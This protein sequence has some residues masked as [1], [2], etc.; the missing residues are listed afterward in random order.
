MQTLRPSY[1][2]EII[3]QDNIKKQL[4]ISIDAAKV[5]RDVL[6]HTLFFGGPGTGKTT[7][8]RAIANELDGKF[9]SINGANLRNIKSILPVLFDINDKTI[10]FIDEI[11]RM[12]K[13]VED[14]LLPCIEDF[15]LQLTT[16]NSVESYDIP[17]FTLVGAT[18]SPGSIS[19]PLLDRFKRKHFIEDYTEENMRAI[20]ASSCKKLDISI[21]DE[22]IKHII[23]VSRG[24]PRV[25]N[26]VLEW[27]RDYLTSK[28]I[29]RL[30]KEDL[31]DVL[32]LFGIDKNGLMTYDN[33]YIECL[34]R[35]GGGP[36]GLNTICNDLCLDNETVEYIIEPWL[37]KRRFI[38]KT[39]KGRILNYTNIK[40]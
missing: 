22:C 14:F 15:K 10:L 9:I 8:A 6:G 19:K 16:S 26:N 33:K 34:E 13:V 20:A 4:Q 38:L 29:A 11:H 5:R 31:N 35:M 17:R 18:T 37:V 28:Y 36:V 40:V 7:L 39:P 30:K 32:E 25:L 2:N 23:Y 3:G 27:I 21:D 24:V 12:T 1:L